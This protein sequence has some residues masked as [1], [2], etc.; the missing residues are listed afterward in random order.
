AWRT[1]RPQRWLVV[2]GIERV[3]GARTEATG[4]TMGRKA[5]LETLAL[6]DTP[7]REGEA[8]LV[9]LEGVELEY[10]A[11][12]MDKRYLTRLAMKH[13]A[14]D[15]Q[16]RNPEDTNYEF[17]LR[18]L[19]LPS[20]GM[21]PTPF[22]PRVISIAALDVAVDMPSWSAQVDGVRVEGAVDALDEMH[23]HVHGAPVRAAWSV[24]GLETGLDSL[25][26]DID[27]DLARDRDGFSVEGLA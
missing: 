12:P 8:P 13:A 2:T 24:T 16:G 18:F 9:R 14:V 7:S 10:S 4:V 19:S 1:G 15:A 17:L 3:F 11:R 20:S 6:H 25:E 22:I 21:D 27:F 23:F 5:S 26:G